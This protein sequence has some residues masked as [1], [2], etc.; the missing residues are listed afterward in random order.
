[1]KHPERKPLG[2]GDVVLLD[3]PGAKQTKRRPVVVVSSERY[4]LERPD[5]LVGLIT[6]Q[7]AQATA[8]TDHVIKDWMQVGLSKPSAYRT[9]LAT[10]PRSAIRKSIGRLSRRDW[11]SVFKCLLVAFGVGGQP[12]EPNP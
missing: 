5:V 1:M 8:N 7:I 10:I 11:Q 6:T 9:F 4:H 12:R 3:F 2:Q